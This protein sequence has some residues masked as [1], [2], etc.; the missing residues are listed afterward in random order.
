MLLLPWWVES[1][2]FTTCLYI[3]T[4]MWKDRETETALSVEWGIAEVWPSCAKACDQHMIKS[5][6]MPK[7]YYR[8]YGMNNSKN[9][10][11]MDVGKGTWRN[12]NRILEKSGAWVKVTRI[13]RSG[14]L[15]LLWSQSLWRHKSAW[16]YS[17]FLWNTRSCMQ[18]SHMKKTKRSWRWGRRYEGKDFFE[19]SWLWDPGAGGWPPV[20]TR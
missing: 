7:W 4:N 10:L 13:P 18:L 17:I 6:F 15:H 9:Y 11:K 16:K 8:F 2:S 5:T 14:E 20:R 3:L 12:G 1:Y 19:D